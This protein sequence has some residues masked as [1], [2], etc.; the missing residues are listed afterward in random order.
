MDSMTI[1]RPPSSLGRVVTPPVNQHLPGIPWT[2]QCFSV[3]KVIDGVSLHVA[4]HRTE[5]IGKLRTCGNSIPR[6]NYQKESTLG[7]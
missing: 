5:N 1:Q 2:L 4:K 7:E 6:E 3:N